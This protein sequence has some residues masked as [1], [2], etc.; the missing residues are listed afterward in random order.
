MPATIFAQVWSVTIA[1]VVE[2]KGNHS[3]TL[4]KVPIFSELTESELAVLAQHAVP[5]HFSAGETGFSEGEPC[6]GP[7]ES[8]VLRHQVANNYGGS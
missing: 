1:P 2:I 7:G 5:R 6:A 3:Q 4:A 8:P